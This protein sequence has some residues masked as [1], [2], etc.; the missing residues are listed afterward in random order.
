MK[1][2]NDNEEKLE[3]INP[4]IDFIPPENLTKKTKKC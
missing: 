3:L 2:K 4:T 1:L